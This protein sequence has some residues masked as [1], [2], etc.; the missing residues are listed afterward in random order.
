M[1]T[2]ATPTTGDRLADD[3]ALVADPPAGPFREVMEGVGSRS[4]P[5]I[6]A[7]LLV[8]HL[9][10]ALVELLIGVL[11]LRLKPTVAAALVDVA[12]RHQGAQE[13][14]F[15]RLRAAVVRGPRP[16][17]PAS[18]WPDLEA[19][20]AR[21]LATND[22]AAELAGGWPAGVARPRR[23]ERPTPY[24][25]ADAW[26]RL[27]EL[28]DAVGDA[29]DAAAAARRPSPGLP[30]TDSDDFAAM[31][32][33]WWSAAA[34]CDAA[35]ALLRGGVAGRAAW[36][37]MVEDFAS[38]VGDVEAEGRR[39]LPDFTVSARSFG[40]LTARLSRLLRVAPSEIRL[41][42]WPHEFGGFVDEAVAVAGGR[43]ALP[44][45]APA[46]G[47][48]LPP[49]RRDSARGG[50]PAD[51]PGPGGVFRR[52]GR[53][54]TLPPKPHAVAAH[55]WN[56][57]GRRADV[58]DVDAAVWGD[59]D[60][61]AV[62]PAR[63]DERVKTAVKRANSGTAE[64]PGGLSALGITI[65]RVGGELVMDVADL[66]DEPAA[67]PRAAAAAEAEGRRRAV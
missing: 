57:V 62:T 46:D 60:D 22:A 53:A 16:T 5:R 25:P 31:L 34:W 65:G 52:G 26:D 66:A 6:I 30:P 45:A 24:D 42:D 61:H 17:L 4:Q 67:P 54:V 21:V 32:W 19:A 7:Y 12:E 33:H 28:S 37:A 2:N 8:S 18:A 41:L 39:L 51:G 50:T 23:P 9:D 10:A 20:A 63:R 47:P 15:A 36:T 44:H 49:T 35:A 64:R 13:M 27:R 55:L 29:A 3:R 40:Q 38:V 11:S 43:A 56:A 1:D 14:T 58:A 48:P 59:A